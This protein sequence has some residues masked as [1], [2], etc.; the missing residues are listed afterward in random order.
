M[1]QGSIKTL[2]GTPDDTSV[3]IASI[4]NMLAAKGHYAASCFT[5]TIKGLTG[6][7]IV[8]C[9]ISA[10]EL[11]KSFDSIIEGIKKDLKFR[12]LSLQL[13]VNNIN[14]LLTTV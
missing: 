12:A 5:L 14:K 2:V 9:N 7:H 4:E 13:D 11:E 3:K 10:E 1:K 6:Q 8:H